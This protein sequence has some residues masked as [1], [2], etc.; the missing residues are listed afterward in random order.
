MVTVD[1]SSD[2]T[3]RHRHAFLAS[4]YY[5]LKLNTR[6]LSM[7]GLVSS[8]QPSLSFLA[9][10][11]LILHHRQESALNYALN[12]LTSLQNGTSLW[13]MVLFH[14]NNMKTCIKQSW[15]TSKGFDHIFN[16]HTLHELSNYCTVIL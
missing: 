10:R 4:L 12:V 16:K 13:K 9:P 2:G 6:A 14:L 7:S 11:Q 5:D 3:V 1:F 15:G 8:F